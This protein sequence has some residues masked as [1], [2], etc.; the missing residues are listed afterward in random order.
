MDRRRHQTGPGFDDMLIGGPLPIVV[1][2]HR[3]VLSNGD[4]G[5]YVGGENAKRTLIEMEAAR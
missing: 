3:A 1:P 2:W 4:L 5:R